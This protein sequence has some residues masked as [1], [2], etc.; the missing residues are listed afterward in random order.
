MSVD[1]VRAVADAVLLEG[2]V[3]YPYRASAVKNRYRWAFG[4]LAPESWSA[5]GSDRSFMVAEALIEGAPAAIRATGHL[6]F[7]QIE[8]R[9]IERCAPIGEIEEVESLEIQGELHL[10]W[11]EGRTREIAFEI[12]GSKAFEIPGGCEIQWLREEGKAKGRVVRSWSA[13]QGEIRASLEPVG[14]R[15]SKLRVEIR[16]TS[17][18]PTRTRAEALRHS[19]VSTHLIVAA[20]GGTFLSLLDPPAFAQEAA[21]GCENEGLYPVLAGGPGRGDLLLAAP[22]I[23]YDHPSVAP[24]S[25]GDFFDATEIDE[26]L[27]LRTSTLTEEEKREARATDPHAARILDRVEGLSPEGMEKLHGVIRSKRD[28]RVRPPLPEPGSRVRVRESARR[29]DAQDALY[30]G[31]IGKVE[32]VMQDVTGEHFLALTLEDDPAAELNRGF[33]RFL[34]YRLDEVEP[35]P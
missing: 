22:I 1:A 27:V 3:L 26:L 29:T 28:N 23:L 2:Y 4:V 32:K 25:P 12:P 14:P 33:G 35:L 8:E 11:E 6:R 7:L 17:E 30:V 5:T 34:Y 20:E 19:L 16:N 9:R 10:P 24:E 15:L 21:K 18:R 13:I 31:R